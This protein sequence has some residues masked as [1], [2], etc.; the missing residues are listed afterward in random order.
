M[1]QPSHISAE[2]VK[3]NTVCIFAACNSSFL[4]VA[5]LRPFRSNYCINPLP[6]CDPFDPTICFPFPPQVAPPLDAMSFHAC[7]V[8]YYSL[9]CMNG[10]D[11]PE[12][13]LDDKAEPGWASREDSLQ[14][15]PCRA[16]RHNPRQTDIAS[17]VE[18]NKAENKSA[19]PFRRCVLRDRDIVNACS[20]CSVHLHRARSDLLPRRQWRGERDGIFV[21]AADTNDHSLKTDI[22]QLRGCRGDVVGDAREMLKVVGKLLL[23]TIV[24]VIDDAPAALFEDAGGCHYGQS[25]K[26]VVRLRSQ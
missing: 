10:N 2:Y 13:H 15:I 16:S 4:F 5:F 8:K 12:Y 3:I 21:I 17:E 1:M 9:A 7:P 22:T 11:W 19:K 20:G 24:H 25:I 18:G 23:V 6:C 14:N 26:V